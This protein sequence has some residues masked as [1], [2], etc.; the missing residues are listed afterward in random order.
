[1]LFG[2]SPLD[3]VATFGIGIGIGPVV[4]WLDRS[5]GLPPF[6]QTLIAPFLATLAAVLLVAAGLPIDGGLVITGS[7][8]RFLPGAAL[9]A[10]MRDLI[11]GSIISGSARLAEALLMGA[12]VGL[13]TAGAIQVGVRLGAPELAFG[14]LTTTT[15]PVIVQV[16]AA[17]FASGLFAVRLGVPARLLASVF[18]LAGAAWVVY[19]AIDANGHDDI[20]AIVGTATV[21]GAVGQWLALRERLPAV[22][23]IVPAILPLL[24]GLALVEGILALATTSGILQVIGAVGIGLALGMGVALGSIIVATVRRVSDDVI[25]PIV[26]EP[27]SAAIS[28][29]LGRVRQ[30]QRPPVSPDPNDV[31]EAARDRS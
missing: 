26:V 27:V 9:T 18:L 14:V 8:L 10:G 31:A 17:A 5:S 3:A 6:F 29:G 20:L 24:P 7:I 19:L 2:G 16:L 25:S 28:T 13:G 21:V 12:A 1:V 23:W 11:D 4:E 15:V 22:I 30:S